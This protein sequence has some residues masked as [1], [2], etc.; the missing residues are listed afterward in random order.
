[1]LQRPGKRHG[2]NQRENLYAGR[3][4]DPEQAQ[5]EIK[6]LMTSQWS[7]IVDYHQ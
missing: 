6:V 5:V 2:S 4:I 1:M 3:H 7:Q